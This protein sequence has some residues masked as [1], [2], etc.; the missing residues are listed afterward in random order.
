V[1]HDEKNCKKAQ[2]S[3]FRIEKRKR[4]W[5]RIEVQVLK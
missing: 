2:K 3:T 1:Y 4:A 5:T